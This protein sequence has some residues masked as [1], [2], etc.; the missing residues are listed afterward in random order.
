MFKSVRV[1][2]KCDIFSIGV[3]LYN[4][5]TLR[6]LV[7]GSTVKQL[8]FKNKRW[9]LSYLHAKPNNVSYQHWNLLSAL[10]EE[11]PLIRPTAY[12][13]LSHPWFDSL[14]APIT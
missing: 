9:K 11:S 12:E 7:T 10:L 2:E 13:A 8:L 1:S 6:K 3:I 14:R 4:M 5:T